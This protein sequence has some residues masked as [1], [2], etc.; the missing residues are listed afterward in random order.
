MSKACCIHIDDFQTNK[1]KRNRRN[2]EKFRF[3]SKVRT[4]FNIP[5]GVVYDELYS[6]CGDQAS[7]YTT[8][9]RWAKWFCAD[10]EEIENEARPGRSVTETTFENIVRVRLLIDDDPHITIEEI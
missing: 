5:T 3:Y 7:Y 10:Q 9:K 4:V 8:A 1:A 2:K 6:V